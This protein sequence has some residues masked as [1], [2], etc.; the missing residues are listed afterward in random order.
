MFTVLPD[1]RGYRKNT[2]NI[3]NTGPNYFKFNQKSHKNY[4]GKK[5]Q[6][7]CQQ[8]K[9]TKLF[10]QTFWYEKQKKGTKKGNK[11]IKRNL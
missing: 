7:S 2:E 11:K 5:M 6:K 4:D 9:T 1:Q 10:Q 3:K 8:K